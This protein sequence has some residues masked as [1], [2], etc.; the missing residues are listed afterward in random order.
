MFEI[1]LSWQEFCFQAVSLVGLVFHL[2]VRRRADFLFVAFIGHLI[3]FLPG[4]FGVVLN[5]YE[6][7][8]EPYVP[9]DVR[10]YLVF[11]IVLV[12]NILVSLLYQPQS[13]IKMK[14]ATSN[15]FDI[16]LLI[17]LF[18]SFG[19][20]VYVG[21]QDLLDVDKTNSLQAQGYASIM[22]T[23]FA[24]LSLL[25]FVLQKKW[26]KFIPA[27]LAM[28]FMLWL[29]DRSVLAISVVALIAFYMSKR[30]LYAVLT[31]KF[32]L[33]VTAAAIGMLVYKRVAYALKSGDWDL[34]SR[35]LNSADILR[36]SVLFSEP[37]VTQ[38]LLNEIV[39]RDYTID[40][41]QLIYVPFSAIPML[42]NVM[43]V[44]LSSIESNAQYDL[45]RSL[46]YG[47]AGN[48]YG[49]FYSVL[50]FAGVVIYA[51]AS[52]LLL[53]WITS[54]LLRPK[55]TEFRHIWA[56][57]VIL[58]TG[59]FCFYANRNDLVFLV[60]L[61]MRSFIAAAMCYL[62]YKL[63]AATYVPQQPLLRPYRPMQPKRMLPIHQSH[64]KK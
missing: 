19:T 63:V 61:T 34:L 48:I 46:D 13:T 33:F 27:A 52:N 21:G 26:I 9:I 49:Y 55:T 62:L 18:F 16:V 45:F 35:Q 10:T 40:P 54:W 20:M 60:N 24:Q 36:E 17:L 28:L 41:T 22:F 6:V 53:V 37:F 11:T 47:L 4:F 3:Y 5:P 7:N 15:H 1:T 44:P 8:T 32:V 12:A 31:P 42:L 38:A 51:L 64:Q 2:L 30:P 58:T 39:V 57:P 23:K 43:G 14:L 56:L 50:G 59:L 25:A 29:G